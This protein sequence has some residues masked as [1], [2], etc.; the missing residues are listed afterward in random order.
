[1]IARA[2]LADA[3]I[4]I[5]DEATEHLEPELRGDVIEAVLRSREGRTTLILAHDVDAISRA[6]VAYDLVD[7]VVVRRES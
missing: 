5:L 2:L 1:M 7:G 4:L 3:P 6:D